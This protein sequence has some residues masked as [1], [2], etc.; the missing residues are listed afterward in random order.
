MTRIATDN[1]YLIANETIN[2][3]HPLLKNTEHVCHENN[4]GLFWQLTL[5]GNVCLNGTL[6]TSKLTNTKYIL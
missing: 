2:L 4:R 5:L 3:S 1:F 6:Q